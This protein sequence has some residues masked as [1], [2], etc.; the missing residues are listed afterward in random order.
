MILVSIQPFAFAPRKMLALVVS[1]LGLASLSCV[2]STLLLPVDSTPYDHQMSRI[3][4]VLVAGKNGSPGEPSIQ[5]VNAWMGDLRNIPYGYH[6][7]WKT[8]AEVLSGEASD[9]KG[10]AVALYERMHARG[11]TNVRLVIG[12]RVSNSRM[13]HAWLEWRT[14]SGEFVL[15]PTFNWM[16]QRAESVSR[17]GAY[18]PLYAYAGSRKYRAAS[19]PALYAQN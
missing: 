19:A 17:R 7:E 9:C 4:P 1:L 8:P 16:A 5:T 6:M 18:L 2:A 3:R 13:T 15:D 11:A 10:K 14:A 12:K